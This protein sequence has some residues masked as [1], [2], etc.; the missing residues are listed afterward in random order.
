MAADPRFV[1]KYSPWDAPPH[2]HRL[3]AQ[4]QFD[5]PMLLRIDVVVAAR[6]S[7]TGAI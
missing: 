1:E 2:R 3:Q 4:N 6:S 7:Q 5:A